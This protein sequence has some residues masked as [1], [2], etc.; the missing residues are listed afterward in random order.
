MPSFG[1][2]HLG[3]RLRQRGLARARFPLAEQRTIHLHGEERG[4]GES[5]VGEVA[6]GA[7]GRRQLRGRSRGVRGAF[8][9]GSSMTD[10]NAPSH[11]W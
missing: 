8:C 7:Q 11:Y 3:E 1:V 10:R 2:Q 5:V 9:H 6:G 4:R